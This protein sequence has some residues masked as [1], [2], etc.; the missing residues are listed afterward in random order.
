HIEFEDDSQET[1]DFLIGADGVNS[2]VRQLLIPESSP[3]YAGYWCWRGVVEVTDKNIHKSVETWGKNGRFGFTPLTHNRI[4]WYACI[5]TNLDDEVKHFGIEELRERFKNY[6]AFI[7]E[8]LSWTDEK[9]L[10]RNPIMDLKP[11]PKYHFEKI[12]LIGDAAHATTPNMGQGAC[13]AI[14]DVAVLQD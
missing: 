13:M 14:E 1:F 9:E 11:I 6:H 4:Y 10:I 5:N 3:R 7:P 8:L 2:K 12:L